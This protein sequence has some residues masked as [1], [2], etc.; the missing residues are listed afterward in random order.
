MFFAVLAGVYLLTAILYAIIIVFNKWQ[1][2]C[3]YPPTEEEELQEKQNNNRQ[4]AQDKT[5]LISK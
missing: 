4:S 1:P 5:P 3:L 2:T